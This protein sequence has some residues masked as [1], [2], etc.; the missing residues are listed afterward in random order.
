MLCRSAHVGTLLAPHYFPRDKEVAE[1]FDELPKFDVIAVMGCG[2]GG[3]SGGDEEDEEE[4]EDEDDE[5]LSLG[6]LLFV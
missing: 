3:G 6:N 4:D 2:P 5:E 1:E